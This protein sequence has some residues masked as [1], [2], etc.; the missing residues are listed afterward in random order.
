MDTFSYQFMYMF[1]GAHLIWQNNLAKVPLHIYV[2]ALESVK[3][4]YLQH[5]F[6]ALN[7]V[8]NK[9]AEFVFN[10]TVTERGLL[11]FVVATAH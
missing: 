11:S 2:C 3:C 7:N 4:F 8:A 9:T 1:R 6:A 5:V 10:F